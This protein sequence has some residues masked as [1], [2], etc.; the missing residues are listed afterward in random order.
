M[1]NAAAALLLL[2]FGV[3]NEAVIFSYTTVYYLAAVL[4]VVIFGGLAVSR[5]NWQWQKTAT[6]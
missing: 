4:P 1:V 6:L 3:D 5:T 2:A